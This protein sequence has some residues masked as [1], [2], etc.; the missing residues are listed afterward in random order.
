MLRLLRDR[1]RDRLSLDLDHMTPPPSRA[2]VPHA[3]RVAAP[4]AIVL[5]SIGAVVQ[6]PV[7]GLAVAVVAAGSYMAGE[8]FLV[9]TGRALVPAP[10]AMVGAGTLAFVFVVVF[11]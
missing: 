1:R 4:R 3:L 7:F 6:A 10:L 2:W 5:G 8:A 11:A 9:R